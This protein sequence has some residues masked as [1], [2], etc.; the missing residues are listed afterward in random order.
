MLH[1]HDPPTGRRAED[2][3][4]EELEGSC[5]GR[6]ALDALVDDG[7]APLYFDSLERAWSTTLELQDSRDIATAIAIVGCRPNL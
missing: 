4:K 2:S 5:R 1:R 3:Q 7:H 6:L